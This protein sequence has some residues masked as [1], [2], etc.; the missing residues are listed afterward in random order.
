LDDEVIWYATTM[1]GDAQSIRSRSEKGAL[2]Q[3]SARNQV[4][5]RGAVAQHFG[6]YDRSGSMSDKTQAE[7]NGSAHPPIA[8]MTAD[9]DFCR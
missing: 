7:H 1:P 9:I 4:A 6:V 3:Q 8:D 2:W 5:L